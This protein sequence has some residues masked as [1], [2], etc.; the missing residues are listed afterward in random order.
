MTRY[1]ITMLNPKTGKSRVVVTDF[2]EEVAESEMMA[3]FAEDGER[4]LVFVNEF[5][6]PDPPKRTC[7]R[8]QCSS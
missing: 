5:Q 4:E 1:C 2:P 8:C 6:V 3:E 7:C